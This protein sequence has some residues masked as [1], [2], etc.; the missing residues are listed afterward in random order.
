MHEL[1]TDAGTIRKLWPGETSHYLAH[2]L[3]LDADSRCR[4]FGGNVSDDIIRKH[5]EETRGIDV[6]IYGFFVDGILR[7]AAELHFIGTGFLNRQGEVAFSIEAPWQSHGV[8]SALLELILLTARNR[9]VKF[10]HMNCMSDNRR[11]Q[12]LARKFDAELSFEFGSVVGELETP[13]PTPLSLM[14][15]II[16]DGQGLTTALLEA[17]TRLLKAG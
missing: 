13:Q 11:M 17:Q 1:A 10:L 9:G 2:L 8:G 12:Q 14:R 15:E 4:R 16:S 7:G 3:R 5:V 6:M